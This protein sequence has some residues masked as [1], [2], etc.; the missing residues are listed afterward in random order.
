[1]TKK[2]AFFV[3]GRTAEHLVSVFETPLDERAYNRATEVL[4]DLE[5]RVRRR[6]ERLSRRAVGREPEKIM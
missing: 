3:A 6:L 4:A 2:T 1:M 5:G